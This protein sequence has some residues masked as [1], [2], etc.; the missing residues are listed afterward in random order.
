MVT[1]IAV[2]GGT[3]GIGRAIA[4]AINRKENYDVKIFSRSV[5][6]LIRAAFYVCEPLLIFIAQ[7]LPRG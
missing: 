3:R 1:T 7:S 5:S 2:A 6:H 4:E